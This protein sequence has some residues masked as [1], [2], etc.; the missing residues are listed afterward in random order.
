MKCEAVASW[1]GGDSQWLWWVQ[2]V[3]SE[4]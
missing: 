3:P 4:K 1:W 2:L